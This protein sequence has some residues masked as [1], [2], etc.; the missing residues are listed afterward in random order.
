MNH[1]GYNANETV[2]PS[3]LHANSFCPQNFARVLYNSL[4]CDKMKYDKNVIERRIFH[5]RAEN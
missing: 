5:D 1:L 4:I 2:H 3:V